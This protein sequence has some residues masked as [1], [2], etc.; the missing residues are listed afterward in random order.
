MNHLFAPP[1][2]PIIFRGKSHTFT[3]PWVM[4]IVNATPDSFFSGSRCFDEEAVAHRVRELV[5]QDVDAI[6]VGAYSTR[7]GAPVVSADEELRRLRMCLPVVRREA[8]EVPLSVD[9]FRAQVARVAV[10]ELGADM[11]N[12]ISGGDMDACMAATMAQLQVPYIVMHTRG[13][14]ETMQQLTAYD[15]VVAD[16]LQDLHDKLARLRDAGVSNLIADPGFG[17]AKTIDQ[18]Y[19]LLQH[20]DSFH[21]LGVPL[22]VGVSRKSMITRVLDVDAAHALNGT[23]TLNTIAL[24]QG[25]HILRVH[26]VR[27]AVEAR[28]LV[29]RMA[30]ADTQAKYESLNTK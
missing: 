15:D 10:E 14:P 1:A 8:P 6:D 24:L 11:I 16:V 3:T 17:F 20:L 7:P 2:S 23:T 30:A 26:D 18:N 9:T 21:R 12:D 29:Q 19:Q 13:T 27:P 4:G 28:T 25:A 22:L 5:D